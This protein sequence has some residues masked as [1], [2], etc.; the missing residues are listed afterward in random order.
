MGSPNSFSQR[1]LQDLFNRT[2]ITRLTDSD[3]LVIF[4]DLHLGDGGKTDDFLTN[5]DMFGQVLSEYYRSRGHTLILNGDIEELQRFRLQA[6]LRRWES[7]YQVFDALRD[8]GRLH[9]LVGNHDM[10]LVHRTGHDFTVLDALRFEYDGH[11]LFVFHGHQT[12]IKFERYNWLM[13][14]GLRYFANPLR[15]GNYSVAHDN[16]KRFRTEQRVYEFS[17]ANQVL[18]IMGHT[19]RPLF[20]SMSKVDSLKFEIERLCRVYPQAN[21]GEQ[22]AI[23]RSIHCLKQ[24]L[25]KIR[26][27][28][29]ERATISSLYNAHLLIPCTFNSGTVIGR[30]GMTCIEIHDGRIE[31]VHWFDE[32][33]SHKYLEYADYD[34]EVLPGTPYHR[35]V[36]KG[37]SLDYIFTRIRLLAGS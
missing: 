29:D 1:N 7:I 14:I 10:D 21:T 33:R 11:P 8:E 4:S 16:G 28:D 26:L 27:D 9:R 15:I 18:A 13:G 31:L 3:R 34:T 37:E 20:E 24:E 6:I 5:S 2:A 36:I 19:H 22:N 17:S 32:V 25:N 30:R 12:M 35:V 23:E